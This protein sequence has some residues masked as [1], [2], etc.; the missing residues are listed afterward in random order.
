MARVKGDQ[1][2]F[3]AEGNVGPMF[4][5]PGIMKDFKPPLRQGSRRQQMLESWRPVCSNCGEK[6]EELDDS[7]KREAKSEM[8]YSGWFSQHCGSYFFLCES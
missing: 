2:D 7:P 6:M 4:D 3:D 8:L 1:Q 5:V